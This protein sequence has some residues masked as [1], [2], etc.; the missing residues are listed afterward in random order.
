MALEVIAPFPHF[1]QEI[2]SQEI[3]Q[4]RVPVEAAR[5]G[6]PVHSAFVD[7]LPE[8]WRA[9]PTVEV[10]S[11]LHWLKPG[12]W[13]MR[14]GF[15]TDWGP[16]P[17]RVE[18]LMVNVGGHSHTEFILDPVT[19]PAELTDRRRFGRELEAAVDAGQRPVGRMLDG[20]LVRFDEQDWHRPMAA[21]STGWRLL[22]RAIRGL[23]EARRHRG[24]RF[25]TVCN[26]YIPESEAER[27]RYQPYVDDA[28]WRTP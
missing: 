20:H 18:T 24:G 5:A 25:S 13:P 11:R 26:G 2:I 12:W 8:R 22:I 23:D 21:T 3:S 7:A 27:A 15:H 28:P 1:S 16:G 14:L 6:G 10:F 17:P 19:P 4:C 9:D